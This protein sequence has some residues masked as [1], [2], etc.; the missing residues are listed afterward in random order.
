[1]I[2]NISHFQVYDARL[3]F[4]PTW[5]EVLRSSTHYTIGWSYILAWIGVVVAFIS[6]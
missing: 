1:M 6:R 4:Y 3:E 5:P 2:A